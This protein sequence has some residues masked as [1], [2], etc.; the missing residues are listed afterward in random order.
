MSMTPE[1]TF[2]DDPEGYICALQNRID[3]QAAEIERLTKEVERLIANKWLFIPEEHVCKKCSGR[4]RRAYAS[5]ATWRGGIGGQAITEDVC[6]SCWGT[7]RIDRKGFDIRKF[8]AEM[9]SL[10]TR[11]DALVTAVNEAIGI[12]ENIRNLDPKIGADEIIDALAA[13]VREAK[14]EK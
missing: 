6:D 8:G 11:L 4:G 7:G 1:H 5:T 13:A 14:G 10:R 12:A 9:K 3:A 2:H